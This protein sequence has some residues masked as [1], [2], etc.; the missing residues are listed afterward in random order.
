MV[1]QLCAVD[2]YCHYRK[3][4]VG[5]VFKIESLDDDVSAIEVKCL[6]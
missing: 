3:E 1:M 2:E 4:E 6:T 5:V